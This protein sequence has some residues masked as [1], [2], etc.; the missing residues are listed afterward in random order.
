[1][2]WNGH[3]VRQRSSVLGISNWSRFCSQRFTKASYGNEYHQLDNT[4]SRSTGK[5]RGLWRRILKKKRKI[6]YPS[7]PMH[8]SYDPYNYAQNFDQDSACLEPENLS[9]SFSARFAG[10][11]RLRWPGEDFKEAAAI[12]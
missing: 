3:L 12:R 11:S 9:R 5:W 1:M 2:D 10:P 6:F 8:L 7:A 4:T